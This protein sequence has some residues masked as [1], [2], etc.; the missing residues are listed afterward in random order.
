[1]PTVGNGE[2]IYEPVEDWAKLPPGWSFK[3]IGS[4]GVDQQRQCLRLQPRRAPDDR[5]RP[6]RQFPALL[7]RGAVSRARTACTSRRTTRS[8]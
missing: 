8:G 3:E 1:M 6:R 4:V 2:Y 7:G 5:V